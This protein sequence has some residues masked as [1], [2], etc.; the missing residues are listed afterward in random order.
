MIYMIYY[1]VTQNNGM[2]YIIKNEILFDYNKLTEMRSKLI[3]ECSEIF[4]HE[5]KCAYPNIAYPN[6]LCDGEFIRNYKYKKVGIKY[7]KGYAE[8]L[9]EYLVSYYEYKPPYIVSLLTGIIKGES[10][11]LICLLDI[12]NNDSELNIGVSS[13]GE[14]NLID[15]EIKELL[16]SDRDVDE[17]I[18]KVKNLNDKKKSLEEHTLLN[19]N[20][21]PVSLYYKSLRALFTYNPIDMIAMEDVDKVLN[22]FNYQI[23]NEKEFY[24][25]IKRIK[26]ENN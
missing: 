25:S 7:G 3:N 18:S 9:D 14:I 5:Y 20:Q 10:N 2:F 21:K 12:L 15:E 19:V 22:F 26:K 17:I 6:I 23:Y 8:D 4:Y 11:S 1:K 16:S 24:K 13:T